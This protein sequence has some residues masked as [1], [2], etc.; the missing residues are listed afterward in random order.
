MRIVVSFASLL[1][2]GTDTSRGY[3]R[4]L[5]LTTSFSP[6]SPNPSV[7]QKANTV[8]PVHPV[9]TFH[10]F[11]RTCRQGRKIKNKTVPKEDILPR[12]KCVQGTYLPS[13]TH[14]SQPIYLVITSNSSLQKHARRENVS[15]HPHLPSVSTSHSNVVYTA[16][17]DIPRKDPRPRPTLAV[18][19]RTSKES[20]ALGKKQRNQPL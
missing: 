7:P 3:D 1:D 17:R 18:N 8:H 13:N 12:G 19:V 20:R 16:M 4:F 6:I 9:R 11:T 14:T 2:E 5:G 15:L 10:A